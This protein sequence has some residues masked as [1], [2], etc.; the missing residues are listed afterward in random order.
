MDCGFWLTDRNLEGPGVV[1]MG[2]PLTMLHR[3]AYS[4]NI[5]VW[6]AV[7]EVV[8]EKGLLDEV[9]TDRGRM[10]HHVSFQLP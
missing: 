9:D 4:G 8:K 5:G 2:P 10:V 3:A 1:A 6:E 7:V